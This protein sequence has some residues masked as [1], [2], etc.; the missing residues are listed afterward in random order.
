MA[1][2]TV[3][4]RSAPM[5][6]VEDVLS[7]LGRMLGIIVADE[8]TI[9]K[10]RSDGRIPEVSKWRKIAEDRKDTV[11]VV[12]ESFEL[13]ILNSVKFVQHP[14]IEFFGFVLLSRG[15]QHQ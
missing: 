11:Y 13:T 3:G 1:I 7:S 6:D 12:N 9:L 10:H 8:S 2:R 14:L 4:R 15:V 5:L